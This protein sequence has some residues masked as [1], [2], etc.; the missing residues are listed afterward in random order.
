MSQKF[1]VNNNA[2]ADVPVVL[3]RSRVARLC[4]S[5]IALLSAAFLAGYFLGKMYAGANRNADDS[6]RI[7]RDR[8]Y[9]MRRSEYAMDGQTNGRSSEPNKKRDT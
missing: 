8:I 7:F 2:G 1:E 9:S 6:F 4:V 3:T 5:G